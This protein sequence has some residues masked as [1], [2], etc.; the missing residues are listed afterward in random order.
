MTKLLFDVFVGIVE[1]YA[2]PETS[3]EH[4]IYNFSCMHSESQ[5]KLHLIIIAIEFKGSVIT[6][7]CMVQKTNYT[8]S[9][10]HNMLGHMRVLAVY[11][12]SEKTY[13]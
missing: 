12:A 4:K 7:I 10:I 2:N 9:E 6:L 8:F 13:V 5:D 3:S 1:K 11:A